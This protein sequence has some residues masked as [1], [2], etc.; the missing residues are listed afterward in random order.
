MMER[1]TEIRYRSEERDRH[2]CSF[3]FDVIEVL[4]LSLE[5]IQIS[6]S[7]KKKKKKKQKTTDNLEREKTRKDKIDEIGVFR[8]VFGKQSTPLPP[9]RST[10]IREPP[11]YAQLR[12]SKRE[13]RD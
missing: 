3:S 12:K 7:T 9:P 6:N 1:A 11:E 5:E 10:E 13:T 2:C 8:F 4:I